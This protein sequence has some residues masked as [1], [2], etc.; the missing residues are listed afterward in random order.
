MDPFFA[1]V[2]FLDSKMAPPVSNNWGFFNDPS[3][4]SWSPTARNAFD[5]ARDAGARRAACGSVDEALF[6]WVAHDVGPRAMSPKG[7][8]LRAAAELVRRPATAV[9]SE[10]RRSP[11]CSPQANRR[12]GPAAAGEVLEASRAKRFSLPA[13]AALGH[14]SYRF[15]TGGDDHAPLSPQASSTRSRS[16]SRSAW[17]ASCWCTS[18]RAIRWSRCCRPTRRRR[19]RADA[20]GLRLR[21][22]AA[23]AVRHLADG[24]VVQGDLGTLARDRPPV[25]AEVLEGGRQH[26]DAGDRASLIG[27]V[28]GCF[29]GGSPATFRDSWIDK[30]ATTL[31]ITG[32]SVPHYW[33]GMVLVIIFSVQLNWLPAMGAGPAARPTGPGT[34]STCST[35]CC[36]RSR[37]R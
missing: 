22:A 28:L 9:I 27:F 7:Q 14:A 34:G 33:L 25:T 6:L 36:R 19:G 10:A 18:R 21:P 12:G 24:S 15:A 20:Q 11:P 3:S 30:L 29:L 13:L 8:G 17:S 31:A 37:C 32:V 23:G 16:R 4:T 5:A 35:W 1:M 2:R 26:A